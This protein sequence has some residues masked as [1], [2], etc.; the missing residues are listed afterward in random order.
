MEL[1]LVVA[2]GLPSDVL[3]VVDVGGI[4]RSQS[5]Q[6]LALEIGNGHRQSSPGRRSNRRK[7][8]SEWAISFVA[9][10]SLIHFQSLVEI[11]F[12]RFPTLRKLLVAAFRPF[13]LFADMGSSCGRLRC[14][15]RL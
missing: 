12:Q 2:V 15:M 4:L 10:P 13:L 6:L 3:L 11:K 5:C 8:L 1:L 14:I 7:K 9:S